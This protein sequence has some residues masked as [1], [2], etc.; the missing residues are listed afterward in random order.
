MLYKAGAPFVFAVACELEAPLKRDE[1]REHD[2]A[3]GHLDVQRVAERRHRAAGLNPGGEICGQCIGE[4]RVVTR[5]VQDAPIPYQ[6]V[7]PSKWSLLPCQYSGCSDRHMGERARENVRMH[8]GRH[9]IIQARPP[10]R[11][12]SAWWDDH[13][14]SLRPLVPAS[15]P[16]TR[17]HAVARCEMRVGWACSHPAMVG[18]P[19][20]RA[21]KHPSGRASCRPSNS[22]GVGA[23]TLTGALACEQAGVLANVLAG[24]LVGILA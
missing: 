21:T 11:V 16:T 4:S 12:K 20:A 1:E 22:P 2:G 13:V 17:C 7:G 24:K 18:H 19:G 15:E 23:E 10:K 5:A 6:S 9:L 14:G 3:V 8:A